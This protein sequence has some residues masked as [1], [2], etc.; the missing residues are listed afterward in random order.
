MSV[1]LFSC[2]VLL[3]AVASPAAAASP[4]PAPSPPDP[5]RWWSGPEPDVSEA[6]DPLAGRRAGREGFK[7]H[8]TLE[9]TEASYHRLWA[10]PPLQAQLVRRGE[11]IIEIWVRPE[12]GQRQAVIRVTSRADG[13]GFLQARAGVACCRP[14]I[15]RRVDV[16]IELEPGWAARLTKVAED[17][18]WGQL[19]DVVIDE[20]DDALEALCVGGVSYDLYRVTHETATHLRRDCGAPE[21]GSVAGVLEPVIGAALGRDPRFDLV[22]PRGADLS[23]QKAAYRALLAAGGRLAAPIR[24]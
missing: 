23:A 16:D 15:T 22:F 20:G 21:E 11:S 17:P 8:P 4:A 5:A 14:E 3:L 9:A 2:I 13:R 1:R 7:P 18:A 6:Q 19:E 12:G 24:R 10:L